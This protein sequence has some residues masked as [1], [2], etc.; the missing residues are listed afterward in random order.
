MSVLSSVKAAARR[1]L[2]MSLW[3]QLRMLKQDRLVRTFTPR[4]VVHNYCGRE[5]KIHLADP[6][7]AG[8]Y[9][10]D[11]AKPTEITFLRGHRLR[12]GATVFDLGAH[13]GVVALLLA[14]A[15]GP[16]GKV[17]ALE[18]NPHNA[19]IARLNRDSNGGRQIIIEAAAIS[20]T[21]GEVTF[22][23][24]LNGQVDDGSGAGEKSA[25]Q[26]SRSTRSPRGTACRNVLFIDVEG[27]ELNA[28]RGATKTLETHPDC[29]IEMH[30][31]R[32]LEKFGGSV[33]QIV[34][35]LGSGY[36]LFMSSETEPTPVPFR[37]GH[38]MTRARFFLTAVA[39]A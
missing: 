27:F 28:L 26:R 8:W 29:F 14:D 19:A 16:S 38:G 23:R 30:V 5:L 4:Q 2:P 25:S 34:D 32:G 18:A 12:A 15:V 6:L 11:W 9:D 24:G 13:Q 36:E 3:G 37:E 33:S 21:I 31:G 20:D 35:E 1:W 10:H 17:V 39:S 22:N 7:G